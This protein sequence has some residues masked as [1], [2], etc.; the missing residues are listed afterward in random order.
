MHDSNDLLKYKCR[1]SVSGEDSGEKKKNG[2]FNTVDEWVYVSALAHKYGSEM[3]RKVEIYDE[4]SEAGFQIGAVV[5]M[6][7]HHKTDLY[8]IQWS[9]YPDDFNRWETVENLGADV[10]STRE[11]V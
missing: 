10:R 7:T 4:E 5:G 11:K 2:Q 6:K 8:E 1:W 3:V 9:W